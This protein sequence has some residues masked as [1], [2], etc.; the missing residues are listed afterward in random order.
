[1]TWHIR[2]RVLE[3]R[4]MG[5]WNEA[6]SPDGI[7]AE[8]LKDCRPG[9]LYHI[10][11]ILLKVWEK[12]ELHSE[13]RDALIVR[14]LQDRMWKLQVRLAPVNNRSLLVSLQRDCCHSLRKCYQN[15]QCDLP[16][17]QQTW[18]SQHTNSRKNAVTKGSLWGG[19][20]YI[21]HFKF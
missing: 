17:V 8:I 4:C 6:T 21:M 7:P 3:S 11:A 19:S 13:L 1:M 15:S 14:Q 12:V 20:I 2:Q 9:L 5:S 16:D 10:Y 18:Y